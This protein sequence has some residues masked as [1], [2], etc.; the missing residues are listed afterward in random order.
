MPSIRASLEFLADLSLYQHQKPFLVL[1]PAN[2]NHA[3]EKRLDN[4]EWETH[5]D[6]LLV[7]IREHWNTLR[8]EECGFQAIY[9][10]SL[11][12]ELDTA[13]ALAS[14]RAE[15]ETL[16]QKRFPSSFVKCY[17]L[18]VSTPRHQQEN[19][20]KYFRYI[21]TPKCEL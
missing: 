5:Q 2:R 4:L 3:I 19:A 7:D 16:L 20:H 1:L 13:H 12:L 17:D 10:K 8:L 9:H 11:S 21:A 6:L 18:K 14:Y 15:T